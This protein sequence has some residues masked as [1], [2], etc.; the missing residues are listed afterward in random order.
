MTTKYYFNVTERAFENNPAGIKARVCIECN[1]YDEFNE[2]KRNALY[3]N[4]QAGI[5]LYK[6]ITLTYKAIKNAYYDTYENY[7]KLHDKNN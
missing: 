2:L 6:R 7:T 3:R 4:H 1:S 5:K